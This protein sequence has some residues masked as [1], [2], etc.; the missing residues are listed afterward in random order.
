MYVC[1]Y[2]CMY[3]CMNE[4]MLI[5]YGLFECICMYVLYEYMY[6]CMY[7]CMY[8]CTVCINKEGYLLRSTHRRDRSG[9]RP[10]PERFSLASSS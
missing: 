1:M 2:A 4:C 5:Q 3:I 8:V 6:V 9:S 7:A 10:C